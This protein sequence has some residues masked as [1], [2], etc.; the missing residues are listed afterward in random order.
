MN[1]IYTSNP[2]L[3]AIF[4]AAR[5]RKRILIVAIDYAKSSHTVLFANGLG[6]QIRAPFDVHN[7]R[8]GCSFLSEAIKRTL[9]KRKINPSHVIIAGEGNPSFARLFLAKLLKGTKHELFQVH[10]LDAKERRPSNLASTDK[11]DLVGIAQCILERRARSLRPL[12][13]TPNYRNIPH[14]SANQKPFLLQSYEQLFSDTAPL[15]ELTRAR[16]R[17][18]Q[19][20]TKASNTIHALVEQL[21]PGFLEKKSPICAFTKASLKLLESSFFSAEQI[22]RRKPETLLQYLAGC[23]TRDLKNSIAQ[24]I[25]RARQAHPSDPSLRTVMQ[26]LLKV[27]VA[28]HRAYQEQL[29]H[30]DKDIEKLFIH[31]PASLL[32]SIGGI[33]ITLAAGIY[34][35]LGAGLVL[36]PSKQLCAYAGVVPR[37][38][39]SGGPDKEAHQGKTPVG[40]NRILKNYLVQAANKVGHYG[41]QDLKETYHNLKANGQH[42]DF[43]IARRLLRSFRHMMIYQTIYIPAQYRHPTQETAGI[44]AEHYR[45][46]WAKIATKWQ[47]RNHFIEACQPENPLGLWAQLQQSAF[48]QLLN[49]PLELTYCPTD[50]SAN[51]TAVMA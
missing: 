8:E 12:H 27:Q 22:A 14:T 50:E 16:H 10:A 30:L 5:D 9:S 32:L 35:E 31:S 19:L 49:F 33:G 20:Q 3:D 24:L 42:A 40:C 26:R 45:E 28:L 13:T 7:N 36:H 34:A 17:L 23:Q 37:S 51:S 21:F 29:T 43:G 38:K 4:N 6:D 25:E 41:P 44:I 18:V 39:Q 2:R 46:Q 48:A 1:T 11:S 47:S 15:R